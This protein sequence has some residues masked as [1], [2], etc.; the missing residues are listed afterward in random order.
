MVEV[1]GLFHRVFDDFFGSRCLGQLAHRHHVGT[2]LDDLFDFQTDFPQVD[3]EVLEHIRRDAG[4]FLHQSEQDVLGADVFVV[5]ALR[6][7]VGELH[8]FSG[9]IG[10]SF[11]HPVFSRPVQ[12][13]WTAGFFPRCTLH[14]SQSRATLGRYDTARISRR[15]AFSPETGDRIDGRPINNTSLSQRPRADCKSVKRSASPRRS[16]VG[17]QQVAFGRAAATDKIHKPIHQRRP[18]QSLRSDALN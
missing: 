16:D 5:E 7:L 4:A 10:K 13:I 6:L 9:S 8:H 3:V 17:S 15:R 2:R 1:A 18:I 12:A 11:V 14:T